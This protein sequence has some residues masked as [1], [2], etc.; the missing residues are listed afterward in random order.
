MKNPLRFLFWPHP[1][2]KLLLQA[3]FWVA[4]IRL[5]LCIFQFRRLNKWLGGSKSEDVRESDW[6]IIREIAEFV[7]LGSRFVPQATCL[8]QALAARTLLRRMG[9]NSLL[10]IGVDKDTDFK[11]VA[12]AWIE[13]DGKIIIGKVPDIRR[14]AI[15]SHNTRQY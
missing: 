3:L 12:H 13:I 7:R 6:K 8:T 1:K 11:L 9:Q 5:G 10:K 2:K 4:F 14:Y 15:M